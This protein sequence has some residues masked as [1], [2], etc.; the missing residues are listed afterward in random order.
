MKFS[1]YS[2]S[3]G[4]TILGILGSMFI[5]IGVL[6]AISGGWPLLILAVVGFFIDAAAGKL[7]KK[8]DL[9]KIQTNPKYA[10]DRFLQQKT[11][12]TRSA[13]IRM[14]PN[15]Q[16]MVRQQ[17]QTYW[18]CPR[19]LAWNE[20]STGS[21]CRDCNTP[22]DNRIDSS[23]P[24]MAAPET[25]KEPAVTRKPVFTEPT[26]KAFV[27]PP[28]KEAAETSTELPNKSRLKSTINR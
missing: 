10:Y 26:V 14:N 15:I 25:R 17:F 19:C 12:E 13:I 11:P 18:V 8:K 9:E 28:L 7:A 1:I 5:A 3:V 2:S 21:R 20:K 23:A 24:V 4:A 16:E 27:E 6:G 22:M